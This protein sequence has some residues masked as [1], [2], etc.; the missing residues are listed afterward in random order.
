MPTWARLCVRHGCRLTNVSGRLQGYTIPLDKRLA[1]DGRGL[2]E[3]QIN[4]QF[5][6][7]TEALYVAESK[8]REAVDM[9]Q[10]VRF[11]LHVHTSHALMPTFAQSWQ[12]TLRTC[13]R[14]ACDR[15]RTVDFV[16]GSSPVEGVPF[17]TDMRACGSMQSYH[18]QVVHGRCHRQG[19]TYVVLQSK[20]SA[21]QRSESATDVTAIFFVHV[22]Q[23]RR[24]RKE[25]AKEAEL[26]DLAGCENRHWT[27][28]FQQDVLTPFG[29]G[30]ENRRR[31]RRCMSC[32]AAVDRVQSKLQLR[33]CHCP[34][35]G[36][37][38]A[39]AAGEG[40]KGGGAARPGTT[41]SDS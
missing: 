18:A 11:D 35:A 40:G 12:P 39:E 21:K 27:C 5:A 25:E 34:N 22:L 37:A 1:A 6:K 32:E 13:R 23:E 4:D 14:S 15:A 30:W 33:P 16:G 7:L 41:K 19:R 20:S 38:G 10:K 3:V 24:L 2:Q 36:G 26:R 31:R 17:S 29:R 9:R 28:N 8:A